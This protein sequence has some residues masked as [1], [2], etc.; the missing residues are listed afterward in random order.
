M[1]YHSARPESVQFDSFNNQLPQEA[2]TPLVNLAV[3]QIPA[4]NKANDFAVA[5]ALL[6]G[7]R[8]ETSDNQG[9]AFQRAKDAKEFE[10]A[11]RKEFPEKYKMLK[12][13]A[14]NLRLEFCLPE[15]AS[16]AQIAEKMYKLRQGEISRYSCRGA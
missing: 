10:E 2:P 4:T 7:M 11:L 5:S 3:E 13:N 12:D 15:D 16:L 8:A 1:P 14:K 6:T 9:S